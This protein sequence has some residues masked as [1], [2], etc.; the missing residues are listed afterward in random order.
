MLSEKGKLTIAL[1]SLFLIFQVST[2]TAAFA[3]DKEVDDIL[4]LSLEELLNVEIVTASNKAEI[5]ADAPATVIVVTADDIKQRGYSDLVELLSDLPGIDMSITYGDLYFKAY[6]R[7]FRKGTTSS[8]LY[9]IDGIVMNHLWYN[10]TDIILATPL[11]NIRQVEVVYG[12]ASSVYG[13]N[14]MMGVINVITRKTAEADGSHAEVRLAAGSFDTRIVDMTAMIQKNDFRLSVTGY[15]NNGDLDK[16]SLE[17]YEWTKSKY[18]TDRRLWGGFLDNPHIAGEASSPRKVRALNLRIMYKTTE[19]G[20]DYFKVGDMLGTNYAF[21]KLQIMQKWVEPE[22]NFFIRNSHSFSKNI[23]ATT[24][25]RYRRSDVSNESFQLEAW[26]SRGEPRQ[27]TLGYWQSLNRSWSVCEDIDIRF[28]DDFSIKTGIKYEEKDLQKAYDLNYGPVMSPQD[29]IAGEYDFPEAPIGTYRGENRVTWKDQGLYLLGKIQ[30]NRFLKAAKEHK[31]TLHLG[32]RVDDNSYY[33]S[34]VTLRAGY[35]GRFGKFGAK[36]MYGQA[37]QE[38]TPRQLYASWA[39]AGSS[40]ELDPEKSSSAELSLSYTDKNINILVNPFLINIKNSIVNLAGG[41]DNAGERD[42]YGVDVHFQSM[43]SI[44]EKKVRLWGY[45]SYIHGEEDKY[46]LDDSIIGTG[47]IGDM[48]THKFHFGATGYITKGLTAN[49]RARYIG[50]R[51]TV[52]TNPIGEVDSYFTMDFN[53]LCRDFPKKG[54]GFSFKVKNLFDTS[55]FHPGLRSASSGNT[56]GYFEGD[57]WYG[58]PAWSNSLL[59]QPGRSFVFSLLFSI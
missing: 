36:F 33:G 17:T 22:W 26:E 25:I 3:I 31:H 27:L 51:E 49:I 24:L 57:N 7:G 50:K 38:P 39:G 19:L 13:P 32:F 16:D 30:L 2:G 58:A 37:I 23:T 48:A 29:V 4:D 1:V 59:P 20:F 41:L 9:M 45:Y 44:A 21:D 53:I 28:S 6:W 46:G 34:Q 11:S 55:Y 35:V 15:L 54:M 5:L 14:A 10:W 8:F 18:L 47:N 40:A 42:I 12:P 43:F 52:E 56:P